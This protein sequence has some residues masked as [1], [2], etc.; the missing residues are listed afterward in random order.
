MGFI[1]TLLDWRL[2]ISPQQSF[3]SYRDM[4]LWLIFFLLPLYEQNRMMSL[5]LFSWFHSHAQYHFTLKCY[6]GC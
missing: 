4:Y 3:S 1:K 5:K 6:Q 2:L